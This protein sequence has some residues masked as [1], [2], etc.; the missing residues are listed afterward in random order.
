MKKILS[1]VVTV[2]SFLFVSADTT[3]RDHSFKIS[4]VCSPAFLS[5]DT[6]TAKKNFSVIAYVMCHSV[7]D[8]DGIDY[9][10]ITHIHHAFINPDSLG[11]FAYNICLDSAVQ[12][13][14]THGVKILA[15]IGGGS[16]P[17]YYSHLLE[18]PFRQE[19]VNNLAK[20]AEDFELDGI[21]V[22]LE[23]PRID[24]NYEAFVT[25]L[26]ATLKPIGKLVTAA[27]ATPYG[28]TVTNKALKQFDYITI[29][30]YDK[31]GPWRPEVGGPHAPYSMAV[32]DLDY[33]GKTRKVNKKRMHLGLPFYGYIFGA[34]S[35][36]SYMSYK[37]IVAAF[38]EAEVK[39]EIKLDNG[40]TLYYNGK[41]TI[42][43]KVQLAL[44][45]AS[46]IMFW[47]LSQ[48]AK[49]DKSLLKAINEIIDSKK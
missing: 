6:D 31:T 44:K 45:R 28:A 9:S 39:D 22:D 42:E 10:R 3:H 4:S 8:I 24:A 34:S 38:S 40:G 26:A 30:S 21:D 32:E 12:R 27:M 2:I 19:L 1:L 47:E 7:E 48:D 14:H 46:G 35:G 49:G 20:L 23:G 5:A 43:K 41:A 11:N 13:A 18:Q 37:D 15:S 17:A 16:A 33:W 29:M 25:E 36:P